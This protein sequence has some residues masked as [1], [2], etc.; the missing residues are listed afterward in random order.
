MTALT[1][2]DVARMVADADDTAMVYG[3]HIRALEYARENC[4]CESGLVTKAREALQGTK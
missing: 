1:P 3:D 4:D 2:D